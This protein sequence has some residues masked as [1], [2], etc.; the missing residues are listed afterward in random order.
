MPDNIGRNMKILFLKCTLCLCLKT[1]YDL[2]Q[3]F[4][5]HNL[6]ICCCFRIYQ[7]KIMFFFNT[8]ILSAPALTPAPA[9]FI[10]LFMDLAPAPAD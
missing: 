1:N 7:P 5:C 3:Y 10:T 6:K 8:Y 4:F 9:P 2:L